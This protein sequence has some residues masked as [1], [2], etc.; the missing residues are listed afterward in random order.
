MSLPRGSSA[1]AVAPRRGRLWRV[2]SS[3]LQPTGSSVRER[4]SLLMTCR[5]GTS[6]SAR[7]ARGHLPLRGARG[8]LSRSAPP[9]RR[10]GHACCEFLSTIWPTG[11]CRGGPLHPLWPPLN[12]SQSCNVSGRFRALSLERPDGGP[13]TLVEVYLRNVRFDPPTGR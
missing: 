1:I 10:G 2:S 13:V 11:F 6:E 8:P 4:T 7:M 3:Q 5:T 12:P 9:G